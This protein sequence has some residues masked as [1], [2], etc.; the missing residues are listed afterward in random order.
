M[1]VTG[2]LRKT[3]ILPGIDSYIEF[4]R[5]PTSSFNCSTEYHIADTKIRY[6][7]LTFYVC[8]KHAPDLDVD[9]V[10]DLRLPFMVL[11]NAPGT[12]IIDEWMT[13]VSKKIYLTRPDCSE[14]VRNR[15]LL[16]LYGFLNKMKP[17]VG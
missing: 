2:F 16:L 11:A 5:T 7:V 12:C 9:R 13:Y 6:C 8:M 3:I 1:S 14:C 17:N 15:L 4:G 10:D